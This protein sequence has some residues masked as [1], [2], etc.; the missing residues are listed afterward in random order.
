[1]DLQKLIKVLEE[2]A[3]DTA[4]GCVIFH[5]HKETK[6]IKSI[7]PLVQVTSIEELYNQLSQCRDAIHH[8]L[9]DLVNKGLHKN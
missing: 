7:S 6:Q 4:N 1:M 3:P 9:N 8:F 5:M 2:F